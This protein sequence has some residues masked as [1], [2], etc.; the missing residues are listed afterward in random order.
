M[1]RQSFN[2]IISESHTVYK[3]EPN[4]YWIYGALGCPYSHRVM[5]ARSIRGLNEIIGL[6]IA[7]WYMGPNGWQFIQNDD[8]SAVLVATSRYDGGIVSTED[9]NS[10]S[11]SGID[12]STERLFVD[13][14]NDPHYNIRSIREL[15]RMSEPDFAGSFSVPVLW[16]LKT[17][18]IVN[19]DSG[20]IVRMLDSGVFD[21]FLEPSN[22]TQ[23]RSIHLAPSG[24]VPLIFEYNNW[25]QANI[26]SAVYRVHN[27]TTQSEFE[28]E[29]RALFSALDHV[30]EKLRKVYTALKRF[31]HDHDSYIMSRFYLFN[32]EITECDIRLFTTMIRF[33]CIY[34]QH[35]TCNWKTI[36][37]DY[38][39]IHLWLQNLYWNE[40]AFRQTTNFD[41]IKL[42][43]AK[44]FKQKNSVGIVP[45][46]PE[47]DILP[48]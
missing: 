6:T 30:E 17:M 2:Q 35:F 26:N 19:N 14:T 31:P 23:L 39:Y 32:N 4:R 20:Q 47:Y 29:S 11:F 9:D 22:L 44:S 33:D 10:S 36:R 40:K 46:G 34:V 16:D 21:K 37:G 42:F 3:P 38:P 28:E 8:P 25:L 12:E 7:H 43:Y 13:G 5:I 15:Y 41:H 45:N 48:L 24:L 27:A 18:T 1:S